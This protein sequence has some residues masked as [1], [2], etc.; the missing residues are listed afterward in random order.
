VTHIIPKPSSKPIRTLMS[1]ELVRSADV[2]TLFAQ[3]NE[4]DQ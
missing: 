1:T 4:P 2:R 3:L